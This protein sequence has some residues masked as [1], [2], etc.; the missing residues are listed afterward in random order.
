MFSGSPDLR[1]F[2]P[3]RR[4]ASATTTISTW[5]GSPTTTRRNST[6]DPPERADALDAEMPV[7]STIGG[8]DGGRSLIAA[9][10]ARRR[11]RP[12]L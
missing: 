4:R 5:T 2:Q 12:W 9:V 7:R 1:H 10:L 11:L 3:H 6:S 8:R